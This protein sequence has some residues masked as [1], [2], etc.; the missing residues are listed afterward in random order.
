MYKCRHTDHLYRFSGLFS[1]RQGESER[2]ENWSMKG[3]KKE[4]ER[5]R[6]RPTDCYACPSNFM[7]VSSSAHTHFGALDCIEIQYRNVYSAVEL[8]YNVLFD[9]SKAQVIRSECSH[10]TSRPATKSAQN[11][12]KYWLLLYTRVS[13]HERIVCGTLG[14]NMAASERLT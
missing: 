14:A 11:R 9:G 8:I 3:R 6:E 4:Q 12:I 2:A 13:V 10:R 1:S 7:S 5:A